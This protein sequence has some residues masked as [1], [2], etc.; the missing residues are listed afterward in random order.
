M[1]THLVSRIKQQCRASTPRPRCGG[2]TPPSPRQA[3]SGTCSLASALPLP[4]SLS[5]A[6]VTL[7]SPPCPPPPPPPPPPTHPHTPQTR[8]TAQKTLTS[9]PPPPPRTPL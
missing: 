8:D 9:L 3:T 5:T 2:S 1:G 7:S 4:P 6:S